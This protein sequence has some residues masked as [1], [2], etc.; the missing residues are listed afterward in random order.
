[1]KPPHISLASHLIDAVSL[2]GKKTMLWQR[3]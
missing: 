2:E 3:G 1:M